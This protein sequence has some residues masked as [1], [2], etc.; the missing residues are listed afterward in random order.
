MLLTQLCAIAAQSRRR[1]ASIELGTLHLES[2]AMTTS[3]TKKAHRQQLGLGF[4]FEEREGHWQILITNLALVREKFG[5]DFLALFSQALVAAERLNALHHLL[6]L[7]ASIDQDRVAWTRNMRVIVPAMWG[8]LY[9]VAEVIRA[10]RGRSRVLGV[11]D[12]EHAKQLWE[13]AERWANGKLHK[14]ARNTLAFHLGERATHKGGIGVLIDKGED[15]VFMQ[16][17]SG[18]MLDSESAFGE[19]VL[20]TGLQID[21]EEFKSL[22]SDAKSDA[23]HFN[24]RLQNLLADV[25]RKFGVELKEDGASP[26]ATNAESE[27]DST[28]R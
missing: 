19:G 10:M 14:K 3:E 20:L 8:Y 25:L 23:E 18:G 9:E 6:V 28:P 1:R 21:D 16:G 13:M 4:V 17:N 2:V 24:H 22:V 7:N 11:D 12:T 15:V 27:G 26:S 5:E